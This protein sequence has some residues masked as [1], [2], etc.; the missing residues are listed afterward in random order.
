MMRECAQ[1]QMWGPQ[2][3]R[4]AKGVPPA[5]SGAAPWGALLLP[6]CMST[7]H[8]KGGPCLDRRAAC[9]AAGTRAA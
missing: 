9:G 3:M 5:T 1:R 2:T 7:G 4:A 6:L 8:K